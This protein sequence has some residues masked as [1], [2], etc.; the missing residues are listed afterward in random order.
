MQTSISTYFGVVFLDSE[1]FLERRILGADSTSLMPVTEG[2]SEYCVNSTFWTPIT[3]QTDGLD[4]FLY[5]GMVCIQFQFLW[6]P[7]TEG[8][9]EYWASAIFS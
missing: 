7:I 9:S 2:R 4:Q 3:I 6:M 1:D 8:R 5:R